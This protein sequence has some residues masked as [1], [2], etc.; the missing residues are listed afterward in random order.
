[1]NHRQQPPDQPTTPNPPTRPATVGRAWIATA[2]TR[3]GVA[4]ATIRRWIRTGRLNPSCRE[5]YGKVFT[6][7]DRALTDAER[8]EVERHIAACPGCEEH[9][10][11]DG[12]VLRFVR[13]RAPRPLCPPDVQERLVARFRGRRAA[14]GAMPS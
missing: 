10:A 12:T 14:D 9:F 8:D 1:M 4:E 13:Q 2:A 5:V 11:F 3:Q 6:Y 7:L